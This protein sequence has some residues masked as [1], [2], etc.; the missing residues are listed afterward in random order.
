MSVIPNPIYRRGEGK[1][2][3]SV[4]TWRRSG[5]DIEL[6]HGSFGIGTR[7]INSSLIPTIDGDALGADESKTKAM[8]GARS[9]SNA[10][11][12][13]SCSKLWR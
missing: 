5:T 12:P 4:D 7:D 13:I 1:E 11:T 3:K 6:I 8:A 2:W 10:F 9:Q